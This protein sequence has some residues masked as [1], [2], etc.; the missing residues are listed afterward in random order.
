MSR[1]D[2][3]VRQ[4]KDLQARQRR[5]FDAAV[6]AKKRE[7]TASAAPMLAELRNSKLST[8]QKRYFRDRIALTLRRKLRHYRDE[9]T[10]LRRQKAHEETEKYRVPDAEV[11]SF[12]GATV[13]ELVEGLLS[14]DGWDVVMEDAAGRRRVRYFAEHATDKERAALAS[15][16]VGRRKGAPKR[17]TEDG[18]RRRAWKARKHELQRI[19]T[20]IRRRLK[21]RTSKIRSQSSGE[22][23]GRSGATANRA[24]GR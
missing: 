6:R 19:V 9:L 22:E 23:R 4:W 18:R 24:H 7:L 2:S 3:Q 14:T 10:Q 17:H 12:A 5:E 8:T 20:G 21:R 1:A 15:A 13:R 11:P 16:L